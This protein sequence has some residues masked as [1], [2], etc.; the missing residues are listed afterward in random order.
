MN[1]GRALAL[2]RPLRDVTCHQCGEDFQARDTRAIFCSKS[3][4][5]KDHYRRS[6]NPEAKV[7][8]K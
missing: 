2:L 6:R 1:A 3:C 4:R 7:I 8:S 5:Q